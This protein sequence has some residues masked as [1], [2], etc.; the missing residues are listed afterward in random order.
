MDDIQAMAA[1]EALLYIMGDAVGNATLC[2]LTGRSRED[3]LR[4]LSQLE[5]K[6]SAPEHGIELVHIEDS[7]QL[8]A[9]PDQFENLIRMAAVQKKQVLTD[10]QL[11][12][13]SIV[14]YRQPVTRAEIEESRGVSC[15][16]AINRLISL[17]LICE[18]GR[19]DTPGRPILFGTTQQFL[20]CFGIKSLDELPSLNILQAEEFK[21]EAEE[22]VS[23]RLGI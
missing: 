13:L 10:T 2:E 19:R 22:E 11:E 12:T 15:E 21:E 4:I 23:E 16:H 3:V 6:L 9:K 17:D 20:R 5:E 8:A 18:V 14:A 1:I 7:V